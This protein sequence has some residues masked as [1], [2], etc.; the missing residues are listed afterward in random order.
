[1]FCRLSICASLVALSTASSPTVHSAE[2]PTGIAIQ[3]VVDAPRPVAN[4]L[5]ADHKGV[6]TIQQPS[7]GIGLTN[8]LLTDVVAWLS[9]RFNLPAIYDHPTV[10]LVPQAK[11]A[12]IRYRGFL[13]NGARDVSDFSTTPQ[14]DRQREVVAV[15]DDKSRTIFLSDSWSGTSPVGVSV[16][17]HEMVHHLQNMAK[18]KFECPAAREKLAYLAQEQW[19]AQYGLN[20]ETEFEIDK[21][22]LVVTSACLP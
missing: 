19:L 4:A 11:L 15:Y 20:L 9:A 14:S 16:L 6:P 5:Q 3:L 17:V 21:L 7:S 12:A 10:E 2:T 13:S 22:T 18:L 8:A 1:M